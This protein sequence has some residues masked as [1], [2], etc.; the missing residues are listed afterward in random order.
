MHL[1]MWSFGFGMAFKCL[2]IRIAS[3]TL[4]Y[5]HDVL[6]G[7]RADFGVVHAASDIFLCGVL[8]LVVRA[9][10]V[11]C[12]DPPRSVSQPD[13]ARLLQGTS[14]PRCASRGRSR[15]VAWHWEL[16]QRLFLSDYERLTI[17]D[18]LQVVGARLMGRVVQTQHRG[19][20][21]PRREGV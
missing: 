6:Q 15:S 8:W 18:A 2:L 20:H 17:A 11:G 13:R 9:P 7:Y 12:D 14:P 10:S 3:V 16:G 1:N 4:R 21:T 5:T 19:Q